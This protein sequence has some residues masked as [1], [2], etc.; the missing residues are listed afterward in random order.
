MVVTISM[1][2][3]LLGC[4]VLRVQFAAQAVPG[5]D[6]VALARLYGWMIFCA[7]ATRLLWT[8]ASFQAGDDITVAT[9]KMLG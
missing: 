3:L 5:L 1:I 6:V 7:S 4:L 8:Y 2:I 9:L